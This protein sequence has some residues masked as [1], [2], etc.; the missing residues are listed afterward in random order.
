MTSSLHPPHVVDHK[1]D[2]N[3]SPAFPLCLYNMKK[4]EGQ[5]LPSRVYPDTRFCNA[6]QTAF[7]DHGSCYTYNNV[8]LGFYGDL[9]S[10]DEAI[11]IRNVTG[12]GKEKGLQLIVDNQKLTRM[13]SPKKPPN[14]GFKV[15]ITVPGVVTSKVGI[16][17]CLLKSK[18]HI[19]YAQVPFT[20]D[21]TFEGTHSFFL[22]GIH[23][24][25]TTKA[26]RDWNKDAKLCYF[27]NDRN[28][29]LFSHY[30]QVRRTDPKKNP[31]LI[32]YFH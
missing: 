8:Q 19:T 3:P 13:I 25:R 12:C 14:R 24:I 2:L 1:G 18:F 17:I 22:H 6:F 27:P 11:K 29:T 15:F 21:T 5:R 32:I 10:A 16:E 20:I 31:T 4:D 28:L 23:N 30:S 7:N 26:F 9:K